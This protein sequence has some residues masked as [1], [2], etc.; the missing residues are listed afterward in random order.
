[1]LAIAAQLTLFDRVDLARLLAALIRS[2]FA[3]S[4]RG[5]GSFFA[6]AV[7]PEVRMSL[8]RNFPRAKSVWSYGTSIILLIDPI[9]VWTPSRTT[10]RMR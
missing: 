2:I 9:F 3:M 6:N 7:E 4:V 5:Q 8:I 10:A 1:L